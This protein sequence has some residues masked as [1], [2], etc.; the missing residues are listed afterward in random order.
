MEFNVI[1]VMFN[2]LM[3][4]LR[5]G[6][7]PESFSH[8]DPVGSRG[9]EP[10]SLLSDGVKLRGSIFFPV[11][12][13]NMQ[14]PAIIICHGIPG[15]GTP[16]PADD[17]GYEG[18]AQDFTSIGFAAVIFNFRGCGESGGDFDMMGW[19]RDLKAILDKIVNTPFID[20]TRIILIGFSGGGAAA[21]HVAAD[22]PNVYGLAVVGTPSDFEIFKKDSSSIIRDFKVRG[23]IRDPNFPADPEK[24]IKNFSEIEPKKWIAFFKG[25]SLL[26]MHG[27][28]DE[29]IPLEQAKELY[30]HAPAGI[31]RLEII[32]GGSHRLRLDKRCLDALKTWSLESLGWKP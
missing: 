4:A 17:P 32:P 30:S 3:E 27:D 11:N 6:K 2:K 9:V 5:M 24:W 26:I 20:P 1:R 21:I 25:K 31:A 16:R 12:R 13:P 10:F 19:S 28:N 8:V 18:L 23:I 15:S 14:Y 22:N 7:T 29:L